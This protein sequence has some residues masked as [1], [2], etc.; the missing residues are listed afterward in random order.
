MCPNTKLFYSVNLRIQSEYRKKRTRNN[1]VFGQFSRTVS[2]IKSMIEKC[3]KCD[4]ESKLMPGF[5]YTTRLLLEILQ[6]FQ[7]KLSTFRS[8]CGLH[9]QYTKVHLYPGK[10]PITTIR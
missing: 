7:A 5:I 10:P 4:V 1:S 8:N 9:G 2:H 6:R 3:L